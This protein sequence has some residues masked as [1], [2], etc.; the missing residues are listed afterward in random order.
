MHCQLL[1]NILKSQ[2]VMTIYTSAAA[3]TQSPLSLPPQSYCSVFC[4]DVWSL[5]LL[6]PLSIVQNPWHCHKNYLTATTMTNIS[7]AVR[8]ETVKTNSP[9]VRMSV[10]A[11]IN[12]LHVEELQLLRMKSYGC[13]TN[14]SSHFY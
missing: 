2:G 9:T 1:Q 7:S 4:C 10:L 3:V 6:N 11:N 14:E 8:A 5:S 13:H 12:N